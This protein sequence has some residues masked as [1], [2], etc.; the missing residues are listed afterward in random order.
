MDNQL[1]LVEAPQTPA[2]R[3]EVSSGGQGHSATPP[4]AIAKETRVAVRNVRKKT[5]AAE[6]M[7]LSRAAA[8]QLLPERQLAARVL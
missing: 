6:A 2:P 5:Q 8:Y 1:A 4:Q 3:G 7:T